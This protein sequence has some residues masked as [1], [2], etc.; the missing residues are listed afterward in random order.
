MKVIPAIDIKNGKCVRLMQGDFSKS[1][2]Y[3][4]SPLKQAKIFEKA[5]FNLLHIVDLDGAANGL[6]S[7]ISII[8]SIIKST[9]MNIQ[10]GG[11]IRSIDG[12]NLLL[13]KG[14]ERVVLGTKIIED[15]NF[16]SKVLTRFNP[17]NIVFALDFRISN[18]IPFLLSRGW[19]KQTK[20]NLFDFIKQYEVQNILA[21][22]ITLDGVLKGPNTSVYKKIRNQ[23]PN[24]NLIG[25]GGISSIGDINQLSKINVKECVV[26][27]AIYEKKINLKDLKNVN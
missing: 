9:E 6:Q 3:E 2:I 15:K 13:D 16:L 18:S 25:S 7:N 11:G 22:D 8:D 19:Q 14:I 12:I 27:K 24:S 10:L 1:T 21:T 4:I 20:I 26:G 5:G 17:R 23:A